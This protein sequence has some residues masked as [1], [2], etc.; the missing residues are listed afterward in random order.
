MNTTAW[1]A[2]AVS[3]QQPAGS[4]P[5]GAALLYLLGMVGLLMWMVWDSTRDQRRKPTPAEESER[6]KAAHFEKIM[7]A[8]TRR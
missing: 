7:R 3:T 5:L 6:R 2:V 8:N 1:I 4:W